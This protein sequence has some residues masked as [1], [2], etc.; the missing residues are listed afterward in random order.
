MN[1]TLI[2]L[3]SALGLLAGCASDPVPSEQLRLTEQTIT[4][5]KAVGATSESAE[6]ALA[7]QKLAEAGRAL[8]DGDNKA[9]RLLAEQG[10]AGTR[11][12]PRRST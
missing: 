3:L 12:W 8:A 9:A 1:K 4:Q 7:E 10:R 11:G 6:L 5:A 2:I